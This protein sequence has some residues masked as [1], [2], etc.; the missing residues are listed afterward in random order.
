M[1][2]KQPFEK[3]KRIEELRWEIEYLSS[4]TGSSGFFIYFYTGLV[5][6]SLISPN[7]IVWF[8][9]IWIT[10]NIVFLLFTLAKVRSND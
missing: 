10:S 3:N 7:F 1:T 5:L 2:N 6:W 9:S 8:F 4:K